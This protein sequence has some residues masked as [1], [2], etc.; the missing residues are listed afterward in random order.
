MVWRGLQPSG[1]TWLPRTTAWLPIDSAADQALRTIVLK[2]KLSG[3][4]RSRRGDELIAR[5][6]S[7]FE[8][9]R[10]QARDLMG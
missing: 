10:R 3:P 8:A 7:A 5:G 9:C 4:T 2:R 1:S 6:V